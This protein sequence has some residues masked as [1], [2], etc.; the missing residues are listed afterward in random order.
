MVRFYFFR[1]LWMRVF[2]ASGEVNFHQHF[3]TYY[4]E[5]FLIDAFYCIFASVPQ[6]SVVKIKVKPFQ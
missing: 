4:I 3:T 1:D 5:S 2:L 6:K